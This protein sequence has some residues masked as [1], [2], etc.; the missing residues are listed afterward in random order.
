MKVNFITEDG[1]VITFQIIES[2]FKTHR[3]EVLVNGFWKNEF[4]D[5]SKNQ[6][7]NVFEAIKDNIELASRIYG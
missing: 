1:K 7:I 3:I 5:W 2:K 6:A 4:G